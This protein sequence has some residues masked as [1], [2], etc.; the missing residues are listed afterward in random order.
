M[1]GPLIGIAGRVATRVATRYLSRQ[2]PRIFKEIHRQDVRIHKSLYGA[3]GGR[4]VRHGRDLA[5]AVGGLLKNDGGDGVDDAPI[6][7]P[8]QPFT[9]RKFNK[10][11]R[12]RNDYRSRRRCYKYN[13]RNGFRR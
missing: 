4:G 9:S 8:K 12:R 11:R 5:A 3:A 13:S 6:R 1:V 10:A 2:V 7:I